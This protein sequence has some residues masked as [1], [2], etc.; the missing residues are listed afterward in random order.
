MRVFLLVLVLIFSLQSWTKADDIRDFEIEGISIG[1]SALDYFSEDK[2]N[3]NKKTPYK[4]KKFAYFS[5][6]FAEEGTY[7]GYLIHFKNNDPKFIIVALQGMILFEHNIQE[8]YELKKE[9]VSQFDKTFKDLKK[10]NWKS[11]HVADKSGKSTT[12]NTQYNYKDGGHTRVVCSDWSE[13]MN[14]LDKLSVSI[15]TREFEDW[16][17]EEAYD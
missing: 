16:I 9:I 6:P 17:R 2:I 13:E 10:K 3:K 8:C 11:K 1:D 12:D 5:G 14:Y 7:G 15:V 4:S